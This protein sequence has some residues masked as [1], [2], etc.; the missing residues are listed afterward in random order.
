[1]AV[2]RSDWLRPLLQFSFSILS[3]HFAPL[4]LSPVAGLNWAWSWVPLLR[5]RRSPAM[6]PLCPPAPPPQAP[7]KTDLKSTEDLRAASV[8]I[9][10]T[11]GPDPGVLGLAGYVVDSRICLA[12]D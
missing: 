5:T 11:G 4:T 9:V 6:S 8:Q 10:W 12:A 1:M 7:F 2:A 3:P